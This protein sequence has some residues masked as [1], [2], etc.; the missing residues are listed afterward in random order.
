VLGLLIKN[1]TK[2]LYEVFFLLISG[3]IFASLFINNG[4]HAGLQGDVFVLFLLFGGILVCHFFH[5]TTYEEPN[6][7][8][9]PF[10]GL[11]FLYLIFCSIFRGW[12]PILMLPHLLNMHVFKQS[13]SPKIKY[14]LLL[15]PN[16]LYILN[17]ILSIVVLNNEGPQDFWHSWFG[18]IF[19]T[20]NSII[21]IALNYVIRLA[22]VDS[23]NVGESIKV[24]SVSEQSERAFSKELLAKQN[25]IERNV[26]LEERESISLSIHNEVG[27]T[28]TTAIVTLDAASILF[29]VD[30]DRAE[31][32]LAVARN[33]IRQGLDIVRQAIRMIDYDD[34]TIANKEL[35][36]ALVTHIE[37]FSSTANLSIRH[38]L[39]DFNSEGNIPRI[40][41]E[42]LTSVLLELLTNGVKHSDA[43]IYM[44]TFNIDETHVRLAVS[45]NGTVFSGLSENERLH[46]IKNGFGIRK[47]EGT[48]LRYGGS[49]KLEFKEG[50][51]V[52]LSL[53]VFK[54]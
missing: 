37:H 42:F 40:H 46:K 10:I 50:F 24:I 17:A 51:T 16:L 44:I 14:I 21:A 38:N 30:P 28:I 53:P 31:E 43:S 1:R 36:L 54:V 2:H 34:E 19:L 22:D 45:D 18:I 5:L 39:R 8:R 52:D 20:L 35:V 23:E 27:H 33:C 12:G 15:S 7:A 6:A 26:R 13:W 3:F 47:I 11:F 29:R 41:A 32:K 25:L 9:H 48:V 4:N 49:F